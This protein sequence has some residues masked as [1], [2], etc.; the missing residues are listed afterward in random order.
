M[1]EG[2]WNLSNESEDNITRIER[3]IERKKS[4]LFLLCMFYDARACGMES[5]F[6]VGF[7]F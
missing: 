3:R 1:G 4:I 7:G 2:R 5:S 6:I